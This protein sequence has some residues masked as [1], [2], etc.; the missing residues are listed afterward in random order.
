MKYGQKQ[1]FKRNRGRFKRPTREQSRRAL[2]DMR[3]MMGLEPLSR[4]EP[5]VISGSDK[6]KNGND[7][8]NQ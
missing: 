1:W 2:D 6:E 4:S 8:K 5:K 7:S 3:M